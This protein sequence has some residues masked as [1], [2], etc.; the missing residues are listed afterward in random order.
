[1]E[2]ARKRKLRDL[3]EELDILQVQIDSID[4]CSEDESGW[5]SELVEKRMKLLDK[6]CRVKDG[7]GHGGG[8]VGR[9]DGA[10]GHSSKKWGGGDQKKGGSE[11]KRSVVD[12]EEEEEEEGDKQWEVEK[13]MDVKKS[14]GRRKF[15]VKWKGWA[16]ESNTWEPE[17]NVEGCKE[18][19]KEFYQRQRQGNGDG[20]RN[21]D[22]AKDGAKNGED[23][24]VFDKGKERKEEEFRERIESFYRTAQFPEMVQIPNKIEDPRL[25]LLKPRTWISNFNIDDFVLVLFDKVGILANQN[26]IPGREKRVVYLPHIYFAMAYNGTKKKNRLENQFVSLDLIKYIYSHN[27][28]SA[29]VILVLTSTSD[30]E[31]TEGSADHWMLGIIH[32][33]SQS[34][35]LL[36]S[37]DNDAI[38][39]LDVFLSL[40]TIVHIMFQVEGLKTPLSEWNYIYSS[41][42]LEQSNNFDCGLLVSLNIFAIL[43][44]IHP[45]HLQSSYG[46]TF[47]YNVLLNSEIP[48]PAPQKD[49]KAIS[50]DHSLAA[51]V[52]RTTWSK[53]KDL[54]D[55]ILIQKKPTNDLVFNLL[56]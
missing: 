34:V 53:I 45:T 6:I 44:N 56:S 28:L 23:D 12:D 41:D 38:T 13:I 15:L 32:K 52:R 3:A 5:K 30:G 35:Y 33:E 20:A 47:L 37:I 40:G 9:H 10:N 39:R 1:M 2:E 18:M 27:L 31:E 24:S 50:G 21:G 14:R 11:R 26:K 36:D 17:E 54:R 43:M 42:C 8:D 46:R 4:G 55:S 16:H 22:G 48:Q 19:I 7:E 25:T 49:T 29:D 51:R